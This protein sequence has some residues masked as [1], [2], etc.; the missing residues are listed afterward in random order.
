MG[1]EPGEEPTRPNIWFEG[2][3]NSDA[4]QGAMDFRRERQMAR[5]NLQEAKWMTWTWIRSTTQTRPFRTKSWRYRWSSRTK[6]STS[7]VQTA[8]KT[9]SR[10]ADA[11]CKGNA[12]SSEARSTGNWCRG[13]CCSTATR[14]V[15]R[16]FRCDS[17][18][19]PYGAFCSF[20]GDDLAEPYGTCT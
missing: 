2:S 12:N 16:G 17:F 13:K 18:V 20:G 9:A 6:N 11:N 3:L 4:R 1:A 5:R 15:S 19:E 10:E 8:S 14:G 7:W